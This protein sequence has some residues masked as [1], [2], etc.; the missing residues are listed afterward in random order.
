MWAHR[1]AEGLEASSKT[2]CRQRR[3]KVKRSANRRKTCSADML[4][5]FR[6]FNTAACANKVQ[7]NA[8]HKSV[9]S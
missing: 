3:A 7:C 8:G 5:Q 6:K 1:Y 9:E 2:T 4:P